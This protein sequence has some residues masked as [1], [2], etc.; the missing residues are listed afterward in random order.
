MIHLIE[1][2]GWSIMCPFS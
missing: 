1:G 2:R